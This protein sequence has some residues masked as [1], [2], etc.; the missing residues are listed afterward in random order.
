MIEARGYD[1]EV[2]TTEARSEEVAQQII[3]WLAEGAESDTLR[4]WH[5]AG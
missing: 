3:R 2:D 5:G 1:L 4:R